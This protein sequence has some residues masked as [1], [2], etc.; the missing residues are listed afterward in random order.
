MEELSGELKALHQT[1]V[2]STLAVSIS[3]KPT[4]PVAVASHSFPTA[5]VHSLHL[6]WVGAQAALV[7]LGAALPF[8][9]LAALLGYGGLLIARRARRLRGGRG[10][11]SVS[12]LQSGRVTTGCLQERPSERRAKARSAVMPAICLSVRVPICLLEVWL[13]SSSR[14]EV[15]MTIFKS[16]AI[17]FVA[18]LLALLVV[19]AGCGSGH[20][21]S[22]GQTPTTPAT[23]APPSASPVVSS[24]GSSSATAQPSLPAAPADFKA[25]SITFVSSDEAFCLGTAPGRG[26][27]VVRTLNRGRTWVLL[28]APKVSLGRPGTGSARIVWGT[29]FASPS[30]GFIFGHGLWETIDGGRHWTLDAEPSG[31]ILSLATIDGQV[32]ALTAKGTAQSNLGPYLL[33][34]RALS[35]GSWSTLATLP[36]VN[37]VD[38]TDLIST[39]AGT[40]AL[41]DGRS[42]LLTTNGGLT[43]VRR[44]TPGMPRYFGA[45]SVAATSAQGLA[46]LCVGPGF[47][48]GAEKLLYKIPTAA[49]TGA[50]PVP[51][52]ARATPKPLPAGATWSLPPPAAR[53]G[54]TARPTAAGP[55]RRC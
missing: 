51:R 17:T 54:S 34:R 16:R 49:C 12:S 3:E 9:V 19:S 24:S 33:L 8:L 52:T 11:W 7:G 55:G 39:Q 6:V 37:L 10:K 47:A 23:T 44:A 4:T 29:R 38:P 26:T 32:L 45:S 28:A 5:F 15:D 50:R 18:A 14:S 40:A 31:S 25:A 30:H 53:A 13:T 48:G 22:G 36:P 43:V 46:L 35:G 2:F 20:P 41:L 21:A 42:V 1:V 27:L